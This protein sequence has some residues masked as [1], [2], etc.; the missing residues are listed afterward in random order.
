MRLH[1]KNAFQFQLAQFSIKA[2][3]SWIILVMMTMKTAWLLVVLPLLTVGEVTANMLN[4]TL[5]L[6]VLFF[7]SFEL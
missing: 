6:P 1:F 4:L 2:I 3:H 5:Y 7:K